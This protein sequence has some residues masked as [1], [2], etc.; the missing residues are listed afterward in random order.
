MLVYNRVGVAGAA[1]LPH[2]TK[3]ALLCDGGGAEK[4]IACIEALVVI[5]KIL[6]HHNGKSL[7]NSA[8]SCPEAGRR[9]PGL[10]G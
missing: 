2:L 4:V 1:P 3:P 7:N 8:S 10:L 6:G 5:K 9:R